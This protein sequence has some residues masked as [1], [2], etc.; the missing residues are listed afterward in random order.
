MYN[1]YLLHYF[2]LRTS[3][4]FGI[5]FV[6]AEY[7]AY[8]CVCVCWQMLLEEKWDCFPIGIESSDFRNDDKKRINAHMHN[9]LNYFLLQHLLRFMRFFNRINCRVVAARAAQN[10]QPSNSV[11]NSNQS[12]IQ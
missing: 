4:C 3:L 10:E 8:F 9:C 2:W 5:S 6:H 7:A 11:S 12:T 1:Y